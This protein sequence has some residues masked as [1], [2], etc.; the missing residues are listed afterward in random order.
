MSKEQFEASSARLRRI[1]RRCGWTPHLS[2]KRSG[3][4]AGAAKRD[5]QA[6]AWGVY[7]AVTQAGGNGIREDQVSVPGY[8]VRLPPPLPGVFC[9]ITRTHAKLCEA[10]IIKMPNFQANRL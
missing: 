10:I 7:R 2:R 4:Y 3:W 5:E 1:L 8:R 6:M 9:A